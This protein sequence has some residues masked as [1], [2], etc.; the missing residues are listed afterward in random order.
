VARVRHFLFR[1]AQTRR[2][3][4]VL[5]RETKS[6]TSE[7][8]SKVKTGLCENLSSKKQLK[9]HVCEVGKQR[10]VFRKHEHNSAQKP[11]KTV[12]GKRDLKTSKREMGG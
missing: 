9:T 3:F 5:L 1:R 10:E 6:K 8:K 11:T 7:R 12:V 4:T 2:I